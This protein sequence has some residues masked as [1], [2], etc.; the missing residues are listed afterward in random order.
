MPGLWAAIGAVATLAGV[1]R[2]TISLAVI[3]FELTNSIQY[4]IPVMLAVLISKITADAIERR[5]IYDLTIANARLP[6]LDIKEEHVHDLNVADIVDS[7]APV[8]SLDDDN[9]FD[10]LYAK[11]A[12]LYADGTA[13]GFPLVAAEGGGLRHYG[14]IASKE[15]EFG[16]SQSITLQTPQIPC[17]FRAAQA[18]RAGASV[19]PSRVSTPNGWDLSLWVDQAPVIISIGSP[20]ELCH[21][22]FAK[23]G[24]RYLVVVDE[25]GL[26]K[27]VIEKNRY[28][29]YLQWLESKEH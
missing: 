24:L 1:T 21:E 4:T 7:T 10:S 3:F 17:T 13:G 26:Y 8:I 15:L 27:G 18:I 11:L 14:Y 2:T 9:T 19:P 23:L 16:L 6:Y 20:M 5:S 29:A 28:L 25:R 22:M 12:E